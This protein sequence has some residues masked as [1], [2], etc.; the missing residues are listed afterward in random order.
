MLSLF[1]FAQET[2]KETD[3]KKSEYKASMVPVKKGT[4][5]ITPFV[6]GGTGFGKR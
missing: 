3:K 4:W 5:E 6:G 2:K 1:T